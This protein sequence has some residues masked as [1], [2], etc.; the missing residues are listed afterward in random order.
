M[1][2][3]HIDTQRTW[4]GGQN[5]V[6]LTVLGL[7]AAGHR[8][9]LVA[10]PEGELARR[11]SEGHDLVR[12][13]PRHEVD[14]TNAWRLSRVIRQYAPEIVHAHDPPAVSMAALAFS[15]GTRVPRPPLVMARR[16]DFHLHGNSFSRWKYGQV[17]CVIAASEAIHHM[18]VGD[19]IP[20]E[21]IVTVH[22]GVDVDRVG[23]IEPALLHQE[24]WLPTQAP[25]V[26][27]IAALFPHKGHRFL[28]DAV[29]L[30]L[31]EVP[32]ARFVIFG[33]GNLRPALERQVAEA[34]LEKHVFLPGFRPDVLAALRAF[35]IFVMSSVTE[36]L[37]TSLL[38]AMAASK[39][40]VATRAGGIPEVV[41]DGETGFLVE[42]RDRTAMAAAIVRLL[43]D[44]ALRV[45]MGAAGLARV[46]A[47]F[48]AERM[49]A[50]T[51]AV[52]ARVAGTRPA[53]GT[54]RRAV[55]A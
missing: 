19:G 4:R 50:S 14:L 1:L 48:S 53:G 6:L 49:V 30:V 3:L 54:A 31:R 8:A 41:A 15:L 10:H 45:R 7:R 44:D 29:P 13:A 36:G 46:R 38:D 40:I 33:E 43:R 47:R 39:P 26:G 2:S 16:V 37:G 11:A 18:L 24:L 5:Q 22:E 51:L 9:V 52:Y 32:D 20:P 27:N 28:I 17:D 21:K 12:L 23:A 25:I 34:R 35:D 42:P 55:G